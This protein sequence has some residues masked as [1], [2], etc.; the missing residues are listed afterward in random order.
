VYDPDPRGSVRAREAVCAYYASHRI[1]VHPDDVFLTANT[2]EAYAFVFHLL[3]DAGDEVWVPAPG[4]P[5][6]D[7]L[8]AY[9]GLRVR[10][11]PDLD[12]VAP[13]SRA[14]LL[15]LVNPG[16]PTGRY[17]SEREWDR[18]AGACEKHGMAAV[19]DEV[20]FEFDWH[21]SVR[22][23]GASR[24]SSLHFTLN[25]VSKMLGLPQMKLAWV[26]LSGPKPERHEAADRLEAVADT[27][28][29][30]G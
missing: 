6:L 18:V 24:E 26:V 12:A 21:G 15:A 13:R 2:S 7:Y 23:S 1:S 11:Y 8:A 3:G 30:F 25:G 19:S 4:Y 5:L 16:N 29:L 10:R 28:C 20:F 9:A 17:V 22:T 14:M 27:R